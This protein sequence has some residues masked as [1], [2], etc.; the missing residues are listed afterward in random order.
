MYRDESG[1]IYGPDVK[2]VM[3]LVGGDKITK[4]LPAAI[5][6]IF[7]MYGPENGVDFVSGHIEY[8]DLIDAWGGSC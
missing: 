1:Q 2:L 3:S 7:L 8:G 4:M 6:T 5:A